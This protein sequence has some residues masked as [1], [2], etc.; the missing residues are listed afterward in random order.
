MIELLDEAA[1]S[2]AKLSRLDSITAR[3]E[4][5][6]NLFDKISLNMDSRVTQ[7]I[8]IINAL[9]TASQSQT[10]V[11]ILKMVTILLLCAAQAH[12]VTL[13]FSAG[14][15]PAVPQQKRRKRKQ[16]ESSV[17]DTHK[18]SQVELV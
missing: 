1:E 7:D 5:M 3:L 10:K 18:S 12:F 16:T 13:I 2:V 6:Q 15:K 9:Q 14:D 11:S 4:D 17:I 8:D